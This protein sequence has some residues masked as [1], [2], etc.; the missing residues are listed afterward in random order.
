[1]KRLGTSS[2]FVAG[3]ALVAAAVL[4]NDA[5]VAARAETVRTVYFSAR[6]AKGAVVTDL[7]AADL[8]VKEGGKSYPIGSVKAATA[9]MDISL[10]VDDAGTGGFQAALAQFLQVTVGH[11]QFAFRSLMPQPIKMLDFTGDVD[12]IKGALGKLGQ[13]GRIQVDGEQIGGGVA[14]AAK[15]LRMRKSERPVIV[16]ISVSGETALSERA[17]PTLNELKAS[18]A[19]LNVLLLSNTEIGKVLGDGPRL[20]GG[21]AQS[22]GAGVIGPAMAKIAEGL[23]S[24][25]VL[26]YTLPD[27]VKP[28][29]RFALTTTR[30]GVTLTAPSRIADK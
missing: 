15:E 10:I 14:D 18:G 26:T 27:G 21:I 28:N 5:F 16:V 13:R 30:K 29:E 4:A 25:Y 1:M 9:P 3:L 22:V 23:M 2:S 24:Q 8:A 11:G 19:S 6:D 12:A 20:S 17:D 7:T